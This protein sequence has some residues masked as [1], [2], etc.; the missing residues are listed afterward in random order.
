MGTLCL[1]AFLTLV[2]SKMKLLVVLLLG[3]LNLVVAKELPAS[4]K[5]N[6]D[7]IDPEDNVD[8][9]QFEIDFNLPKVTDPEEKARRQ[10]ALKANE[11]LIKEENEAYSRGE[12]TWFDA[13]NEFADLPEDEFE[14]EKTG[15]QTPPD[16][17]TYGRGLLEPTGADRVDFAS[18]QYFADFRR[19]MKTNRAATPASYDSDALGLVSEVKNQKQCGSC[20]AFANMAAIETCFKKA[21]GVFGDYSEQQLVDC[22]YQ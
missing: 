8:E 15:D 2:L 6:A 14:A 7:E 4:I 20:V 18:E 16:Y 9:D 13:V 10:A 1:L 5:V 17:R 12:K 22:G 19:S 3:L 21:T 11:A